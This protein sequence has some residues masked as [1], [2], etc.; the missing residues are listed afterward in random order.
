MKL[1]FIS[2]GKSHDKDLCNSINDFT[3]RIKK[4][5]D[6]EWKIIG[7]PK[8]A[9]TLSEIDTKKAEATLLQSQITKDDFVVLLDE[10]GKQISS[11]EL[12]QFIQQRANESCKRICF[13]IGGAYGVD[14]SIS[15]QANYILSFSK[16]V[17][18]HQ[19]M[20]LL[21]AEQVY[22]ACSI[23]RNEKYHHI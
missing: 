6:I 8:N 16:M 18:P 14:N 9:A 15:Q 5:F 4:Y 20:R 10:R 21:L 2:I 3:Y 22:R 12:A 19:I 1:C 7:T 13:I 11:V 17:F 23:L